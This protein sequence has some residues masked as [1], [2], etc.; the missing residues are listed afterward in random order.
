MSVMFGRTAASLMML[1]VMDCDQGD[2]LTVLDGVWQGRGEERVGGNRLA[3]PEHGKEK[4]G[5]KMLFLLS[6][7]PI[8]SY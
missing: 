1:L 6:I 2:S 5:R 8:K 3:S 4:N 7:F